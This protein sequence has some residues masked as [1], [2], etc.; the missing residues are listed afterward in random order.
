MRDH[1]PTASAGGDPDAPSGTSAQGLRPGVTEA[2]ANLAQ[3][4]ARKRSQD[5]LDPNLPYLLG[6]MDN[7]L[8]RPDRRRRADPQD[9]RRQHA[10]IQPIEKA[11]EAVGGAPSSA[12]SAWSVCC[13]TYTEPSSTHSKEKR[14]HLFTAVSRPTGAGSSRPRPR[15][16][17]RP[18]T[19]G[20]W[21][22]IRADGEQ[23]VLTDHHCAMT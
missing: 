12:A 18:P 22:H 3:G 6:E 4:I 20:R 14:Q 19:G 11:F 9:R 2:A 7:A 17:Q 1:G 10:C 8:V 23:I 5:R 13:A 21:V 15:R 16:R